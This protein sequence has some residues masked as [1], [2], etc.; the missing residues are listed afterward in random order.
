MMPHE[1]AVRLR[2][3]LSPLGDAAAPRS[4]E[5]WPEMSPSA[6]R[7][8]ATPEQQAT[9]FWRMLKRLLL[10]SFLA[11]SLSSEAC[12][13]PSAGDGSAS[14][15]NKPASPPEK[16]KSVLRAYTEDLAAR[17][18]ACDGDRQCMQRE[19][20]KVSPPESGEKQSDEDAAAISAALKKSQ[21]CVKK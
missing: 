11:C 19:N 3:D 7:M 4:S 17:I 2:A 15:E 10:A 8:P 13:K 5:G 12:S 14:S 18:C 21:D 16:K 9:I 1:A 6:V 20:D